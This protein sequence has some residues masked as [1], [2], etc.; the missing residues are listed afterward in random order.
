M[1]AEQSSREEDPYEENA[2][3]IQHKFTACEQEMQDLVSLR[4]KTLE[5]IIKDKVELILELENDL[6]KERHDV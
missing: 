2:Q 4:M 1:E 3:D 6:K 5:Q